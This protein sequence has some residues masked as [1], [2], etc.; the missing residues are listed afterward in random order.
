MR[1]TVTESFVDEE[2]GLYLVE[3]IEIE[4]PEDRAAALARWV[5]FAG[6]G[7]TKPDEKPKKAKKSTKAKK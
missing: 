3:G 1:G 7:E 6:L 5:R 2:R 4:V